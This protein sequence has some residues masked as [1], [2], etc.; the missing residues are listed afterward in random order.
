MRIQSVDLSQ[1]RIALLAE[2]TFG[3]LESKLAA[4]LIRYRGDQV[5][6]VI[7]SQHA[8][9]KAAEVI[10]IGG[11]IPIVGSLEEA[12][13]YEPSVLILGIAPPGGRLPQE[14]RGWIVRA[15]EAGLSVMSGLHTFLA[16]DAEFAALARKTGARIWDVRRPP[17]DLPVG[18]MRALEIPAKRILTVGSDC[19][20]GK[21]VAAL[22]MDREAQKRGIRSAFC[23]TGQIGIMIAGSGI[24]VDAVVSDF[25]S[26]ATEM[27]LLER[28]QTTGAEWLFVE[29][30][31][32]I[33]HPSYSGVTLGLL[34]GSLPEAMILCHHASRRHVA[35][36]E[37]LPIPPLVELI[38]MYET[39]AAW[40]V[41]A[42]VVGI[43]LNTFDLDES[44][45]RRAVRQAA[46]ETGLPA[47]DPVRF[48]AGVLVDALQEVLG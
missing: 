44:Q 36:F 8:G 34:H 43:A 10:G 19:R 28:Y 35:R 12:L 40:L 42:K 4:A 17:D 7:D 33:Q 24:A 13:R 6:C 9:K 30:Q 23:A 3:V 45:A 5:V 37:G 16:E 14:W 25:V 41:P 11:E 21:M 29:G 32:S 18:A 2:K 47:T 38:A 22:E 27:I 26:G 15:L 31:G 1:E 48:G 39:A 20:V 46:E